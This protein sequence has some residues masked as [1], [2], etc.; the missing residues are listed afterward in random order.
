MLELQFPANQPQHAKDGE[1]TPADAAGQQQ[2]GGGAS[3]TADEASTPQ[4][5]L[6]GNLLATCK[7]LGVLGKVRAGPASDDHRAFEGCDAAC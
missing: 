3:G 6:D 5:L 2:C 4:P 7:L 1:A